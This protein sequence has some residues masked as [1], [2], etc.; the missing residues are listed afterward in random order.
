[1]FSTAS[2]H[3][4]RMPTDPKTMTLKQVAEL[5]QVHRMAIYRLVKKGK[6]HPLLLGAFGA[7]TA[8]K[9]PLF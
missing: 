3:S 5:L 1:M 4:W 6:L 2:D 7:S 9:S 8:K